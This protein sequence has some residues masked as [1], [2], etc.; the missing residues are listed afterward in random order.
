[1]WLHTYVRR[2]HTHS[3][4][5]STDCGACDR[6]VATF[7]AHASPLYVCD[8]RGKHRSVSDQYI[9][10]PHNNQHHSHTMHSTCGACVSVCAHHHMHCNICGVHSVPCGV[11]VHSIMTYNMLLLCCDGCGVPPHCTYNLQDVC[12]HHHH[13][14][15]LCHPSNKPPASSSFIMHSTHTTA[16]MQPQ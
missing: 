2:E 5:I 15:P 12:H 16:I 10:Q 1:M 11:C 8:Q 6:T 4:C 14:S 7:Y 9:W 3:S 13:H